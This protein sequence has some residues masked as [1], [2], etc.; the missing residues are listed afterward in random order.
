M[1]K[2]DLGCLAPRKTTAIFFMKTAVNVVAIGGSYCV[3][4]S[5]DDPI[6]NTEPVI[7]AI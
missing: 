2:L 7:S 4:L 6:I 5:L 1:L 3:S